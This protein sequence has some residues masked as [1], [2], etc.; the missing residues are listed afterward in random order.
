M[1]SKASSGTCMQCRLITWNQQSYSMVHSMRELPHS[2]R[3]AS[4][5]PLVAVLSG[6][7][8]RALVYALESK[9]IFH[10]P[11]YR[12]WHR[13]CIRDRNRCRQY[14]L[15]T[16]AS[17]IRVQVTLRSHTLICQ[18]IALSQHIHLSSPAF[19]QTTWIVLTGKATL[20]VTTTYL[21]QKM[22]YET[23]VEIA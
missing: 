1:Y 13:S 11:W 23:L 17:R 10:S 16:V 7:I 15:S 2:P 3:R 8:A 6:V 21:K 12:I 5:S 9:F 14:T 18:S 20:G 22:P 4:L 19:K